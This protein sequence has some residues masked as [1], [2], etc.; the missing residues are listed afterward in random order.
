MLL[1]HFNKFNCRDKYFPEKSPPPLF[2]KSLLS[3]EDR[4]LF[5]CLFA[6][7]REINNFFVKSKKTCLFMSNLSFFL[8]SLKM[9]P[10]IK[11]LLIIWVKQGAACLLHNHLDFLRR[12]WVSSFSLF[13]VSNKNTNLEEP[14]F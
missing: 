1:Y 9:I 10:K 11:S 12:K 14:T 7:L 13:R 2:R 8:R 5:Q 3:P 4:Y 6:E